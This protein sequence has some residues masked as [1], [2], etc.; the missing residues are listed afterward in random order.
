MPTP[1]R[2]VIIMILEQ[3]TFEAFE[4]YPSDSKKRSWKLIVST[5]TLCGRIKI[6]PKH[7]YYTFCKACIQKDKKQTEETK[8]K[9]SVAQKGK[10]YPN[11]KPKLKCICLECGKEFPVCSSDIERGRGKY[12]SRECSDKAHVGINSSFFGKRHTD[13]TKA[14]ISAALIGK[15][16][17][18]NSPNFNKHPTE[19]TRALMRIAAHKRM[20]AA[21]PYMTAPEKAFQQICIS[22]YLPFKFVGDGSLWLGNANPDFVHNTK[23]I[24]VEVFGDYWHSLSANRKVKY[25]QTVEGRREQLKKEGYKCIF[26]WESD[27]KRNDA[28]AFV[29]DLMRNER[30]I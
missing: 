17:G 3:E 24:A 12:C 2:Q 25:N 27:L 5:C 9:K 13:A 4:Y 30:L 15:Y 10:K 6:C 22:N 16:T 8:A 29:I 7:D 20:H 14:K 18:E 19:E 26:I 11:R 23:K 21:K 28:E 1:I